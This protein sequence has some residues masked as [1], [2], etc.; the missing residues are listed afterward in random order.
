MSA[1]PKYVNTSCAKCWMDFEDEWSLARHVASEHPDAYVLPPYR[2]TEA[3]LRPEVIA[4]PTR[5]LAPFPTKK[6]A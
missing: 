2:K 6:G 5:E 3:S 4:L 1:L